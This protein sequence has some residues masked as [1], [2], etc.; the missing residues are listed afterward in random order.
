MKKMYLLFI[1]AV[2]GSFLESKEPWSCVYSFVLTKKD[3]K[4][5]HEKH[6]L[7]YK[8]K[9]VMPF[10]QLIL[11]WNAFRPK[12][13][14]FIV[15]V[16]VRSAETKKW[17]TW[18]KIAL[19]G[20][21]QKSFF[22]RGGISTYNYCRL[23]MEKGYKGDAFEIEVAGEG[24]ATIDLMYGLFVSLSNQEEF[25]SE[26][27][28]HSLI[29]LKSCKVK[30]PVKKSQMMI[31]HPRA[32]ALCSPTS[33]SILVQTLH[34]RHID[35]LKTAQYVYDPSLNVFGNWPFNMAHAFEI[36]HGNF[37]FHVMR[38]SSFKEIYDILK[39]NIPVAVSIRGPIKGGYTPYK[40]GHLLV[41]VGWNSDKNTVIC[42]D[43]ASNE[44]DGVKKEYNVNDFLVAWEKSCRLTY[45]PQTRAS[46]GLYS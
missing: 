35:P 1:T 42:F 13:D 2:V 23:E 44:L 8:E 29:G 9:D 18:H 4:K 22:S 20:K 12:K 3:H 16:R 34:K 6:L 37:Y 26:L 45:V 39:Q 36:S 38:P 14:S 40:H 41:V 31:N 25:V 27:P 11:S 5:Y 24:D 10:T 32:N 33:V 17:D 19:W 43:P 46:I 28:D 21:E 7:L 15:K 30:R